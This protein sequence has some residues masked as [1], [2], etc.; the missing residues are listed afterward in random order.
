MAFDFKKK[1]GIDLRSSAFGLY[2]S[3]GAVVISKSGAGLI[4]ALSEEGLSVQAV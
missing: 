4:P 3:S 2:S 1:H